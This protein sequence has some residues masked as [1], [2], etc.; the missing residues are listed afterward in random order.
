MFYPESFLKLPAG[1][2]RKLFRHELESYVTS[3]IWF[4]WYH[5]LYAKY[6]IEKT[7]NSFIR[8]ESFALLELAIMTHFKGG[9]KYA[10]AKH[11]EG[12]PK[13]VACNVRNG[14]LRLILRLV[15]K[16]L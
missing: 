10:R 2:F 3:G 6:E 9:A 14:Y 1:L 12:E 15:N 11:G 5:G 4:G 13:P 16:F 7:M 8:R